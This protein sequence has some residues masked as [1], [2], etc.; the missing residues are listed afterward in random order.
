MR[1]INN[2][3]MF[4]LLLLVVF[5]VTIGFAYYTYTLYEEYK[6]TKNNTQSTQ[7]VSKLDALLVKILNEELESALYLAKEGK[8]D[9]SIVKSSRNSVNVELKNIHSLLQTN[10][11]FS[12]YRKDIEE[13]ERN[14]KYVHTLVDTLSKKYKHIFIDEYD[15]K[16]THTIMNILNEIKNKTQVAIIDIEHFIGYETLKNN[17]GQEKSFITYILTKSQ[18]MSDEELT[19][20]DRFIEKTSLPYYENMKNDKIVTINEFNKIALDEKISI[21]MQSNYGNYNV[22][23]KKWKKIQSTKIDKV[24]FIQNDILSNVDLLL[25]KEITNK[26]DYMMQYLYI[27]LSFL[28]L[29]FILLL[30]YRAMGRDER[31]LESTL[32]SIEIGLN[33]QKNKELQEL[34]AS[35]NTTAIYKFLAETINE[36]NEENKETFLANMSHEIRTPLNGIIGFTQLLKDTPLNVEQDEFLDIIHTS[37]NHLVGIIND[38]LDFSKMGAGKIEVEEIEFNTFETIESAVE[39]YAAK[40]SLKDVVYGLYMDPDLPRSLIGDPTKLSQVL[41]NLI[42]NAVKFTDIYGSLNVFVT[43]A[44]EDYKK[45]TLQFSVQDTGIGISPEQK[46]KIFE[47]FS[48]ADSS[49]SRK[50]GGTGL[51]LSI[52]S[53]LVAIMGGT[54]NVDSIVGEGST[55]FFTLE[56]EKAITQKSIDYKNKYA[57]LTIGFTLPLRNIDRQ[58]DKN[59]QAYA[60]YMGANFTIYYEDEI[61]E[62]EKSEL[63]DILFFDLRYARKEGE[64]ERF[65]GLDTKLVVLTTGDMQRDFNVDGTRVNKVIL[66]PAN[67]TKVVTA[68]DVCINEKNI[69]K[70]R[71]VKRLERHA[72]E[73]IQALVVEDNPINQK[74]IS[75]V[76]NEFGLN[77]IVA[78]DGEE[79]VNRYKE[80]KF[81][82]VFMDIQ[83]PVMGGIEATKEIIAYEKSIGRSHTHIIALTAN[84]LHGDRE[85]YLE[86]GMD[87]YASKPIN[88]DKLNEILTM[89][90]PDNIV[91]NEPPVLDE[92]SENSINDSLPE[93]M[94]TT[95]EAEEVLGDIDDNHQDIEDT[96]DEPEFDSLPVLNTLVDKEDLVTEIVK[97]EKEEIVK[98]ET[99]K[100]LLYKRLELA[101]NVYVRVLTNLGFDI[102]VVNSENE[103]L[104]KIENNNYRFVLYDIEPFES[105]QCLIVDIIKEH[106]A[107][108]FVFTSEKD[109]S[110]LCC[111]WLSIKPDIKEIKDKFN[112]EL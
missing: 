50:Y 110:K 15:K 106:Y 69:T 30:I 37:S 52:S 107:V 10:P 31:L 95:V 92:L 70:V 17:L 109:K 41:I 94:E 18:K 43:K 48:Q 96:M 99:N 81:D 72:F 29:L 82:I 63:P 8:S 62:L 5:T 57:D 6:F 61:F 47:A 2:K 55:F 26:K 103:F 98:E 91:S 54:L 111:S 42:S 100:I 33:P 89:Y 27:S 56:F 16:I 53:R 9:F 87:N 88:L 12:L 104:D 39:T 74:L 93:S 67:F 51:G 77:V 73:N 79:G 108:P 21:L 28:I 65:Y 64:L 60:E 38:I 14:L 36:A 86:A 1:I 24:Q 112:I 83:M 11:N 32:K 68:I 19:L 84:A 20:W 80:N 22:D 44:T 102:E 97:T 45:I 76:L 75:R 85:K 58:I 78:N 40:A 90:F 23:I 7:L 34:I 101:T 4:L 3:N 46:E 66:K 49:T 35:R 59:L 13:L 105:M 25:N 71:D